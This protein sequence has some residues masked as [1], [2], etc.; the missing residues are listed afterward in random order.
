MMSLPPPPLILSLPPTSR[1]PLSLYTSPTM[2]SPMSPPLIVSSPP[3]TRLPG[4]ASRTSPTSRA[5]EVLAGRD[6]VVAADDLPH[7]V[8]GIALYRRGRVRRLDEEAVVAAGQP[9]TAVD[10][11]GVARHALVLLGERAEDLVVAAVI[12]RR[13][14]PDGRAP[15]VHHV[16]ADGGAA[17][18]GGDDV[19]APGGGPGLRHDAVREV[20]ERAVERRALRKL[21]AE[22]H[23][24]AVEQQAPEARGA[25][26]EGRQR[27]AVGFDA[28]AGDDE[29]A[30]AVVADVD[31][32]RGRRAGVRAS[33]GVEAHVHAPDDHPVAR[34]RKIAPLRG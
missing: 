1:P 15:D 21:G 29:V 18:A 33:A 32:D 10:A 16:A 4:C 12:V 9:A 31:L 6:V 11:P 28:D 23:V 8:A 5:L 26:M 27:D 2:Y 19:R 3:S 22:D 24:V 7:H 34:G 20:H 25:A 14:R 13:R 17:V 30:G